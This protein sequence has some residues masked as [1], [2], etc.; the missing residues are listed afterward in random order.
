MNILITGGTGFIGKNLTGSLIE[1]GHH[2]F[3]LTRTP[4]NYKDSNHITHIN[5][6]YPVNKLPSI[7]AVIN[8]AGES[9]FGYWTTSK[10]E[11]ILASRIETT[12]NITQFIEQM[13]VK[14]AVFISGSA[15][16]YYGTSNDL[17]FTE[18]TMESGSDFLADVV[19]KWENTAKEVERLGIRTIYAR[20]GVVL[21]QD[22]ALPLMTL[23]VK[24][25]VGGRIGRGE[26]WISWIHIKDVV[27]LL[28][29]CLT[30]EE[31]AGPLNLTAPHPIRN[32][33]FIKKLAEISN[34][35]YSLPTPALLMR[36]VLGEMSEL[37]TKGQF[38]LPK[39]AIANHY[40]YSYPNLHEALKNI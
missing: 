30:N 22:G 6:N 35:P 29:Y 40:Q 14:P 20:F 26:Q 16:G 4:S 36:I 9:L 5:Y 12:K 31:I 10:K 34:R 17:I 7:Y 8:L 38:V 18:N 21:G 1:Q 37:I 39:K 33:D 11:A 24:L 15:V 25:F 28:I 2:V 23:P 27:D 3:I 32:K 19:T 13:K